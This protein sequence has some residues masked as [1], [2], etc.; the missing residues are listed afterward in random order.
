[1]VP[2]IPFLSTT[3]SN[4][5]GAIPERRDGRDNNFN[6]IRLMLALLVLLG[7]A[8]EMLDGNKS[9]EPLTILFHNPNLS[10][11]SAAVAGFFLLSGYLILLSWERRPQLGDFLAKRALRIYPAFLVASLISA[12]IVGAFGA[13]KATEYLSQIKL[14]LLIK[15][16]LLLRIPDV[17]PTFIHQPT[18]SVNGAMWTIE[19]EF[20]CYLLVAFLGL[21][22]LSKRRYLWLALSVLLLVL[23]VWPALE[24]LNFRGERL[25][26][27]H[28]P[29]FACL[30][31]TFMAGGCFYLFRDSIAFTRRGCWMAT[32]ALIAGCFSPLI[33]PIALSSAG[34]YLLFALAWARVPL[35]ER[36]KRGA[37]ISYGLYLYGWPVQQL[38][39][40]AVP[41]LP[42]LVLFGV[43]ALICAICGLASWF[44]V[45]RPFLRLKPRGSE[46]AKVEG[47]KGQAT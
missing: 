15:S 34:A 30:T 10:L 38:A 14:T 2:Q 31:G 35:L 29:S 17:P 6:F 40:L 11:G 21:C 18:G 32:V 37:D 39:V 4:P 23:C 19:F 20:R 22:G 16:A 28:L 26:F 5:I 44:G 47:I 46:P 33:V 8:P 13:P 12:F 27:A 36:F 1:M 45:E 24:N 3:S 42:P 7:H 43:S 41:R 9:R 25:L